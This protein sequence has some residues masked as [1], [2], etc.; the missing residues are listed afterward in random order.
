MWDVSSLQNVAEFVGHEGKVTG[1]S[2]SENGYFMASCAADKVLKLW[3]L[4]KSKSLQNIS[5]EGSEIPSAVHFDFS[6]NNVVVTGSDVTVFS[7]KQTKLERVC[8]F[9]DHTAL[10]TDA[11]FG[12]NAKFIASTSM[13]R[14]LKIFGAPK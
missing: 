5:L 3:D 7:V 8:K 1:L 11:K 10:V 13:D 2:F 4:R 6:G 12:N 9:G 14:T